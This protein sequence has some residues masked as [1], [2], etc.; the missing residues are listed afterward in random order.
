MSLNIT[1]VP[2]DTNTVVKGDVDE[3]GSFNS[4]DF[5]YLRAYLLG[6]K[7]LSQ[8]QRKAADVDNNGTVD[9]IDFAIMRQVLLGI[10]KDF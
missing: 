4:I 9:S 7:T 1:D 6:T 3:N 5:G 8:T 2:G 10:K